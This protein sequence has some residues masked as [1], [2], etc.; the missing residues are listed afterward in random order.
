MKANIV[1]KY[2]KYGFCICYA[3]RLIST[4]IFLDTEYHQIKVE[5][6][7]HKSHPFLCN[8]PR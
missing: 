1:S 5:S 8:K 4:V 6:A 3:D 7:D 2:N